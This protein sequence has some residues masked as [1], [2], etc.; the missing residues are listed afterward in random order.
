MELDWS[1]IIKNMKGNFLV[2]S[3][4]CSM[5]VVNDFFPRSGDGI[6]KSIMSMIM[7]NLNKFI[8]IGSC[9]LRFCFIDC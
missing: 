9:S 8:F 6:G 4:S 7:L 2:I 3:K 1:G 5:L